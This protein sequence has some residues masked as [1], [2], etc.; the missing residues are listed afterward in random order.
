MA[1]ILSSLMR[2]QRWVLL[3]MVR[4][5][6]EEKDCWLCW[7]TS[8]KAEVKASVEAGASLDEIK[9]NGLITGGM[10]AKMKVDLGGKLNVQRI[11]YAFKSSKAGKIFWDPTV[12]ASSEDSMI[13]KACGVAHCA[14]IF[15][16]TILPV[17]LILLDSI[18][19]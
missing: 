15:M 13:S 19:A 8:G 10:G 9:G 14:M 11:S 7:L 12:G 5:P 1:C 16:A 17:F 3:G 18:A 4:R 2:I 6:S